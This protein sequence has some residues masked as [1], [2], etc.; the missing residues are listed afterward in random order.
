MLTFVALGAGVLAGVAVGGRLRNLARTSVRWWVLLLP[1]L[2]LVVLAAHLT[3]GTLSRTAVVAGYAC[4]IVVAAANRRLAGAG[5]VAVGLLLNA[6]VISVDSGMPVRAAALRS[7]GLAGPGPISGPRPGSVHHLEHGGDH[8]QWLDD[9]VAL[10]PLRE[11]V[12]VGD[13][14]LAVG[15]ADVVGHVWLGDE[16]GRRRAGMRRR[17]RRARLQRLFGR[18]PSVP[19]GEPLRRLVGKANVTGRDV[20]SRA[21]PPDEGSALG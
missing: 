6:A 8:L 18:G 15:I 16:V 1:G 19:D 10:R 12:S 13:L 4:L 7:A 11:V 3:G 20:T 9:R 2:G 21:G 14:V 5:V 17:R